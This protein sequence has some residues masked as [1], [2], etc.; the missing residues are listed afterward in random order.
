MTDTEQLAQILLPTENGGSV[1]FSLGIVNSFRTHTENRMDPTIQPTIVHSNQANRPVL[2]DW[3]HLPLSSLCSGTDVPR[4]RGGIDNC[5][6]MKPQE[7]IVTM[8]PYYN[9]ARN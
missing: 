7:P 4:S 3:Y 6:G 1:K 9:N 5:T 2:S 8:I